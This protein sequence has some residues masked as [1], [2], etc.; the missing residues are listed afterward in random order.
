LRAQARHEDGIAA[1]CVLAALGRE[2]RSTDAEQ[3]RAF[4]GALLIVDIVNE[5]R[6]L[7]KALTKG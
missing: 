2:T 1:T 3:V 6:A 4:V 7:R 5:L